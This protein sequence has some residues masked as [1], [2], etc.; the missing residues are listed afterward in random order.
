MYRTFNRITT[1]VLWGIALGIFLPIAWAQAAGMYTT[2]QAKIIKP[3]G[4]PLEA[5]SIN[6]K[7]TILDPAGTCSLYSE[8]YSS[9]NMAGTGGLISFSLGS[10]IKTYPPSSTTFSEVFNNQIASLSCDVGGPVSYSPAGNDLRKIVMQFNDGT[11]WQTLPAMIINHVPYAMYARNAVSATM[12][13]NSSQLNGKTDLDFVQVTSIPTCAASQALQYNGASFG[14]VN[15]TS[16]G[17]LSVSGT[18]PIMVTGSA[19][20][21]MISISVASMSSNGYLTSADYA[22]FNAKLSASSTQI[23]NTLGYAPVSSS[24]VA[25]QISSSNLSGDVSGTISANT[26]QTVGGKTAAQIS[27]SVNDT[28]AATATSAT[29]TIVKRDA[30]GNASFNGASVSYLDIYKPSSSFNIRLQAPTSLSANYTLNLPT[31]S[32]GSGQVLSTDGAGNLSWINA[33]TGSVTSVSCK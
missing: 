5:S 15:L 20:A 18:A 9:V 1:T 22:E 6:F 31:T 4:Y 21:P 29:N 3:D 32:G 17:V 7:F 8:T 12:A 16:S 30:S 11:G 25:T 13:V 19:A 26:V 23:V 10:G 14:C 28:L 27:A 24:A 33:A 2:Y